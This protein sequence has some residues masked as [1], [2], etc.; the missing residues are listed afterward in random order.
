MEI[1]IKIDQRSK[2]AKTV[3]EML[4]TFD[5]VRF[6]SAEERD[7]EPSTEQFVQEISKKVKQEAAKKWY[8]KSE[9]AY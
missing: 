7:I 2:Q 5:F 1:T 6:V 9:I 8:K 3:L 4:K